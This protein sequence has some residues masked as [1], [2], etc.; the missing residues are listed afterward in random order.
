MLGRVR[1]RRRRMLLAVIN[2]HAIAPSGGP[3]AGPR[4][5]IAAA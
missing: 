2:A 1:D 3:A 4:I 5:L